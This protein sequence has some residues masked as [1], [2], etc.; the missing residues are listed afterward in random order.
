MERDKRGR[1]VGVALAHR[2]PLGLNFSYTEN[3]CDLIMGPNLVP[4]QATEVAANLLRAAADAYDDFVPELISI[5]IDPSA[6]HAI[7]ELGAGPVQ[8]GV[9]GGQSTAACHISWLR[10]GLPRLASYFDTVIRPGG[11]RALAASLE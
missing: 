2:G 1:C 3:R 9:V 6:A 11:H 8:P 4:S 10:R 7:T 5:T